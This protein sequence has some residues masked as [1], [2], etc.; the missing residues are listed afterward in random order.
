MRSSEQQSVPESK[1]FGTFKGVFLPSILT[2]LGVIMYLRMGWIV[3]HVGITATLIIVTISSAIT[4]L[5]GLSIAATATNMR[6][7]AGGAYYMISRSFGIEA[8]AAIGLPL[9][10]AQALGVSFY[11]AGFAESVHSLLPNVPIL[12]IGVVSLIF[13]TVVAYL[14]ANLALKAQMAIFVIIAVSLVSFFLGAA[15]EGKVVVPEALTSPVSF[16]LAFA[17]FFPAVTGIEAGLSMSGDLKNSA[18][19]LPLG[20]LSAVL[21]GYLIYLFIPI[22]L[23]KLVPEDVLRTNPMIMMEVSRVGGLVLL[24]IWGAT[25]SSALG[26]LLGAP[27]TLQALARDRVVP[28]FLGTGSANG[29]EPRIATGVAFLVGLGGI[30]LGDLNAIAPVLSMFFLTSYGFLNLSAGFEG[31]IGNPSWRPKFR[32][33][34]ILSLIGAGA[35]FSAML[36]ID[37][38]A[39]YGAIFFCGLVYWIMRKRHMKSRW[40]D[41]RRSLLLSLA[42]FAI[43]RLN[44]YQKNARSWRPHILVLSGSPTLRWY[45]IQM[46]HAINQHR[47][48]LT[49]ASILPKR[50]V[51]SDRIEGIKTSIREFLEKQGVPALVDVHLADNTMTGVKAL[52]E[53]YG[54]GP[55]VPNTIMLGETENQDNFESFAELIALV[56]SLNRN[57][58][59]VRKTANPDANKPKRRFLGLFPTRQQTKR[60]D[61]WWSGDTQNSSLMLGLAYLLQRS[62]DWRR[63]QLVVRALVKNESERQGTVK[64]LT[65][66]LNKARLVADLD[67]KVLGADEPFSVI[68][69]YSQDADL[70]FL[71][72]RKPGPT[73]TAQDYSTYYADLLK[74]NKTLPTTVFVLAGENLEFEE[75][76]S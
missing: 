66:F 22:F 65:D 24:G 41:V 20:T 46:A 49:V 57:L 68:S 6:V 58:V 32:T 45:L 39:T 63:S 72:M 37:P 14:S 9:F 71:G 76:F 7:G 4:F 15:P 53:N 56:S 47:S 75:I 35:C 8:G 64:Y 28:S 40:G 52:I 73:Q 43:Y 54:I 61:L 3:G 29:D 60:I 48:F 34:W 74:N 62:Y 30:M 12:A 67:I 69:R 42:R 33:P 11:I 2:I 25:L 16:W 27:R 26:A 10:L 44:N 21:I 55:L 17:V 13:L 31:L 38:G 5:T 51:T 1:G 19:S 70:V 59:V 23:W 18:K 36:M 50:S